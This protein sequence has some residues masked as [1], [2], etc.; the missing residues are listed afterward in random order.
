MQWFSDKVKRSLSPIC[1]AEVSA[2]H[3]RVQDEARRR[4]Q[5]EAAQRERDRILR[6]ERSLALRNAGASGAIFPCEVVVGGSVSRELG[7]RGASYGTQTGFRLGASTRPINFGIGGFRV[8]TQARLSISPSSGATSTS[9]NAW[10]V[11]S[12]GPGAIGVSGGLSSSGKAAFG[13]RGQYGD[14][15]SDGVAYAGEI[16]GV[17]PL[18]SGC[19]E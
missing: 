17:W 10:A 11:R 8:G 18:T 14:V 6:R 4:A 19:A 9:V 1:P 5:R 12:L 2:E 3:I 13:I 15:G 16:R 7:G